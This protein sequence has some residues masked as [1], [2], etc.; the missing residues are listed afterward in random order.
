M[1]NSLEKVNEYNE[2]NESLNKLNH[3]CTNTAIYLNFTSD[4][5]GYKDKNNTY[6]E[7]FYYSLMGILI[8]LKVIMKFM[9]HKLKKCILTLNL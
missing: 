7:K 9:K 4:G 1:K 8:I 2:Q 6:F 3:R 5:V